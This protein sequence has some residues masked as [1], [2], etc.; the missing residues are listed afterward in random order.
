MRGADI[1]ILVYDV[2]DHLSFKNI[3]QYWIPFIKDA[4]ESGKKVILLGNK[5]DKERQVS[6]KVPIG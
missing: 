4:F 3:E 5:K 1:V 2:S 6:Q